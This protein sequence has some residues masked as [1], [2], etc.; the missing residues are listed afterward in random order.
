MS[1]IVERIKALR[2]VHV[3]QASQLFEEAIVEIARLRDAIRRLAGQDATMSVCK[4]NVTVTIDTTLTEAEREAVESAIV[5]LD[6]DGGTL[7][8]CS[9]IV[10][11]LRNL[12]ERQIDGEEEYPDPV[13]DG[14]IG[15][16]GR[17]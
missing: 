7:L 6:R 4:G 16:D 10:S 17:P 5:V 14:W 13:R 1:D 15:S 12:L 2:Y 11:T 3:P 8:D 9:D